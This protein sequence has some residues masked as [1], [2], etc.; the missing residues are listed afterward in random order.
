MRI[1][2]CPENSQDD[3]KS[4][5]E[6]IVD[7]IKD[8]TATVMDAARSAAKQVANTPMAA[9]HRTRTFLLPTPMLPPMPMLA[10]QLKPSKPIET[11]G[12]KAVQ[13][14][15]NKSLAMKS[16]N[17]PSAKPNVGKT[18]QRSQQ[19]NQNRNAN[20]SFPRTLALERA[21]CISTHVK[22]P[23]DPSQHAPMVS[24]FG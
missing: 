1:T 18:Q 5:A 4:I 3:E 19:R 21:A 8:T 23:F 15:P 22:A 10:Q 9:L 11:A 13:K 24:Y 12:N 7:S 20:R 14:A 6:K 2:A 17:S 16:T